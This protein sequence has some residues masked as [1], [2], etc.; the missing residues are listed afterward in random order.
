MFLKKR[1]TLNLKD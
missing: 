1:C